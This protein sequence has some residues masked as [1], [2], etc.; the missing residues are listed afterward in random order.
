MQKPQQPVSTQWPVQY[1]SLP[2]HV[3]TTDA[4]QTLLPTLPSKRCSFVVDLPPSS[5]FKLVPATASH[6]QALGAASGAIM[7]CMYGK[8]H[9]ACD[10]S[11]HAA[12]W[13][14]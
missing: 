6:S 14:A 2:T 4:F 7:V 3:M 13:H 9:V 5:G 8:P 1:A 12:I 10:I 11:H